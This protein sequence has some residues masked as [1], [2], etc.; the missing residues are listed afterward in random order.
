MTVR[1][2]ELPSID[3]E[4]HAASRAVV[5]CATKSAFAQTIVSP[6][7]TVTSAGANAKSRIVMVCV[8]GRDRA[9]AA[10]A[11]IAQAAAR[12]NRAMRRTY[13]VSED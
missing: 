4:S 10:T 2:A 12:A 8:V 9:H 13:F 3:F 6:R 11:P 7:A 5:V 1:H